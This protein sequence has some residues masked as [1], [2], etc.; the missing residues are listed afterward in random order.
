VSSCYTL[1]TFTYSFVAKNH[2]NL[3]TPKL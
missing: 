2:K 1:V 3:E